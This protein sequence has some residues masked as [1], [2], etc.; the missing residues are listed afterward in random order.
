MTVLMYCAKL[1][2]NF[3]SLLSEKDKQELTAIWV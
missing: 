2:Q 1:N 3:A